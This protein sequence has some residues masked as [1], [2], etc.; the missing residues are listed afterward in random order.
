MY[1]ILGTNKVMTIELDINNPNK[2]IGK[3][4][5]WIENK[6]FGT[7]EKSF[8][9]DHALKAFERLIKESSDLYDVA[10]EDKTQQEIFKL[11]IV[12]D[13]DLFG[14]TEEDYNLMERFQRF[15]FYFGDQFDNVTNTVYVKNNS[16]YF[17]WT[18]TN[19]FISKTIDNMQNFQF[20]QVPIKTIKSVYEEF[21]KLMDS[22]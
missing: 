3:L 1:K 6:S 5:F 12:N 19:D 10:F 11:S 21:K 14:L 16:C 2:K 7:F 13:A 22:F 17:L 18:T 4:R 15:G 20:A 9:F 8:S